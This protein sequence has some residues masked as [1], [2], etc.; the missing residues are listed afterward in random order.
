MVAHHGIHSIR[1]L[2]A[3]K[4]AAE[5]VKFGALVVDKVACEHDGITVLLVDE[6]HYGSRI[7]LIAVA[8]CAYM[9][10]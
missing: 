10:V 6:I 8:Q 7:F 4:V 2:Q 3:A 5:S 1:S 9:H